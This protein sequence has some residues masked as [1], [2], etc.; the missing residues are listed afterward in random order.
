MLTRIPP[1][2]MNAA[3][4]KRDPPSELLNLVGLGDSGGRIDR[5]QGSC[6]DEV[7]KR[8]A[9]GVAAAKIAAT[10]RVLF[11]LSILLASRMARKR[12]ADRCRLL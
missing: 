4:S 2:I 5:G 9:G 6:R 8:E 7:V 10:V 1:T 3:P 12:A 11:T